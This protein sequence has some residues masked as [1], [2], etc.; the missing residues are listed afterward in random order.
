MSR[1]SDRLT[2]QFL[3]GVKEKYNISPDEINKYYYVGGTDDRYFKVIY[4]NH[5]YPKHVDRCVCGVKIQI[6]KYIA[7][8]RDYNSI[9]VIGNEC[10]KHFPNKKKRRCSNCNEIHKNRKDNICNDCR[11]KKYEP[12]EVFQYFRCRKGKWVEIPEEE[13]YT[14]DP[15]KYKLTNR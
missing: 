8:N 12:K 7:K 14:Y 10:M 11:L 6:N 1:P 2:K 15:I 5:D 4:P 13:S 9:I 3:N